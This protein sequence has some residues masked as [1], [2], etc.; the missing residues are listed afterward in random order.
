LKSNWFWILIL[1][2]VV[3]TSAV[4]A[5]LLL[6]APAGY[7]RIYKDGALTEEVNLLTVTEAYKIHIG[8]DGVAATKSYNILEVERG[9]IRVAEADCPDGLCIRQGWVS[10]GLVPIVCLPNTVL[11]TFEGGGTDGSGVDAVVG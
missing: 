9:R 4:V 6:R 7:A 5:L 1:S 10:G 3:I 8:G 2:G 11:V